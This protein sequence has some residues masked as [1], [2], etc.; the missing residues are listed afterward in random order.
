MYARYRDV[1]GMHSLFNDHPLITTVQSIPR[2]LLEQFGES[3][4]ELL[5]TLVFDK[6]AYY[7][8]II[9]GRESEIHLQMPIDTIKLQT[10]F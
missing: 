4:R 3:S 6:L 1:F 2:V 9:P 8:V 10:K 7:D 5:H